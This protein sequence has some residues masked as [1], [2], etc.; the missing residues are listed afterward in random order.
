[1][2]DNFRDRAE[3]QYPLVPTRIIITATG[4]T[5]RKQKTQDSVALDS[6]WV[7]CDILSSTEFDEWLGRNVFLAATFL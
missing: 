7:R 6:A 2:S 1:V 4:G 5:E 3:S